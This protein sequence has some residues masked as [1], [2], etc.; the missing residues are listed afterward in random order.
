VDELDTKLAR[1]KTELK[2]KEEELNQLVSRKTSLQ[3]EME[4]VAATLSDVKFEVEREVR[5]LKDSSEKKA[6]LEAEILELKQSKDDAENALRTV[7]RAVPSLEAQ[8]AALQSAID[9]SAESATNERKRIRTEARRLSRAADEEQ[10]GVELMAE[11]RHLQG[12]SEELLRASQE[13]A[14]ANREAQEAFQQA[15]EERSRVSSGFADLQE[16]FMSKSLNE[17]KEMEL[18][19]NNLLGSAE[20]HLKELKKTESANDD[21]SQTLE[22]KGEVEDVDSAV[23][24]ASKAIGLIGSIFGQ[25]S[26]SHEREEQPMMLL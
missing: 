26:E 18:Q 19:L 15:R 21:F 2:P 25:N 24:G 5:Y 20:V 8:R 14:E 16:M 23:K 7:L 13:I 9:R 11:R 3:A 17:Q 22:E 4:E 10:L 6:A 1:C 12:T